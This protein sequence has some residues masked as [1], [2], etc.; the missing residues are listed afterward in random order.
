MS[1]RVVAEPSKD[2]PTAAR[3]RRQSGQAA[4]HEVA[5]QAAGQAAGRASGSGDA[6]PAEPAPE[7]AVDGRHR[8]RTQN[9]EAVLDA[10]VELFG[11]GVYHPSSAQIAERAGLSPRSLFRYFDD[12]DDLNRAAID[13]QL[14]RARPLV[15]VGVGADA[16]TATK[17]SRLV[18]ARLRLFEAI[19]PAAHAARVSAWRHPVVADQL[20]ASRSYLRHQLGRLFAPELAGDQA[21]LAALDVLCSFESYELLRVAQGLPPAR[22]AAALER[23]LSTLLGTGRHP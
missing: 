17:I 20:R 8:R 18:D 12:I 19:A 6:G 22:V 14:A 1:A 15:E 9:R 7:P 23:A 2:G 10:L 3:P 5:G 16:P 13:R 21:V 11:E 4:G